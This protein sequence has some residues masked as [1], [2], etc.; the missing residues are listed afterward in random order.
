MS[1]QLT[2]AYADL[3]EGS[4]DCPDRI[5]LNAYFRMGHSAGGF[6]SWWRQLHGSDDNLDKSQQFYALLFNQFDVIRNHVFLYFQLMIFILPDQLL[7]N[8]L[9]SAPPLF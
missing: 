9:L 6:R 1:D 7:K 3:I 4:Y 8:P 2:E 5:V